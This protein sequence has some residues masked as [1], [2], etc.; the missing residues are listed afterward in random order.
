MALY[1]VLNK[2]GFLSNR[3][4]IKYGNSNSNLGGHPDMTRIKYVE[5]ST[6][7]LGHG[8]CTA[9]GSALALKIK[10]KKET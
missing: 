8:F 7:S 4:L 3:E 6:G 2:F 5:A 9:V 10:K 1:V